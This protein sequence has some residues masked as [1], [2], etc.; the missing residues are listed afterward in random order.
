MCGRTPSLHLT[1][2][3]TSFL[4]SIRYAFSFSLR[5]ARCLAIFTPTRTLDIVF[6]TYWS[7]TPSGA[8]LRI[9]CGRIGKL[10]HGIYVSPQ[11]MPL[12]IPEF[13][14]PETASLH[15]NVRT[16][17]IRPIIVLRVGTQAFRAN[18]TLRVLVE[19]LDQCLR[20]L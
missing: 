17:M 1:S 15:S 6:C 11:L 12:L 3:N 16:I 9:M 18:S 4:P 10:R 20:G 7:C 19:E 2:K 5:H 14:V 13:S 8:L